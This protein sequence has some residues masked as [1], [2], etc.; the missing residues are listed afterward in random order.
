MTR[1][2]AFSCDKAR[3]MLGY[4]PAVSLSDAIKRTV[5]HFEH[6][7]NPEAG[8]SAGGGAKGSKAS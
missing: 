6:L 3:R 1:Q 2:R 4:I 7:R 5:E 8:G